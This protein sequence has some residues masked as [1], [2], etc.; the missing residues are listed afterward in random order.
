MIKFRCEC[1]KSYEVPEKYAGKKVRCKK[2]QAI[3]RIPTVS[4]DITQGNIDIETSDDSSGS[5]IKLWSMVGLACLLIVLVVF[6]VGYPA[7]KQNKL[8]TTV[9]TQCEELLNQARLL[10]DQKE[11]AEAIEGFEAVKKLIADSKVKTE[12]FTD[13]LVETDEQIKLLNSKL[14]SQQHS[15]ILTDN[16]REA[17][18]LFVATK[19]DKASEKYSQI[20][21]FLKEHKKENDS[22]FG[23]LYSYCQDRIAIPEKLQNVSMLKKALGSSSRLET[24]KQYDYLIDYFQKLRRPSDEMSQLVANLQASKQEAN[25]YYDNVDRQIAIA[26]KEEE[27]KRQEHLAREKQKVIEAEKR[28]MELKNNWETDSSIIAAAFLLSCYKDGGHPVAERSAFDNINSVQLDPDRKMIGRIKIDTGALA[29]SNVIVSYRIHDITL[30]YDP[31]IQWWKLESISTSN[32]IDIPTNMT[33][34]E[35]I[36]WDHN[37]WYPENI[38]WEFKEEY[39]GYMLA[40]LERVLPAKQDK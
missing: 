22:E 20:S 28:K 31:N 16:K 33:T 35:L 32:V 26:K 21:S 5:N 2:C 14:F 23:W 8:I 38:N 17:D 3:N 30:I 40:A 34:A 11:F 24:N 27:R 12:S 4:E 6:A 7:Y 29:L 13:V 10:V 36:A 9:S 37:R 39:K 19:F 18:D 25:T 1:G 15:Q